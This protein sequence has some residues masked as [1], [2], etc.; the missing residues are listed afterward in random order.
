MKQKQKKTTR[1]LDNCQVCKGHQGG[2]PGNENIIEGVVVC[3]YCTATLIEFDRLS[4]PTY[5]V[6]VSVLI[7][8]KQGQLLLGER[9]NCTAAGYLST[10]GGR[11]ERNEDHFGCAI[12][13]VKE[14]TGMTLLP[15]WEEVG[16]KELNRFGGH[17]FMFYLWCWAVGGE[18]KNLEPNKCKGWEWFVISEIPTERCTE[19]VDILRAVGAGYL[20]R[21]TTL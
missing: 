17:Y 15:Y 21:F 8:N 4:K 6:G 12:R 10:P 19:P 7:T 18:P 16:F 2:V 13:E 9:I 1:K 11:I 20:R 5:P 14:E 3:D